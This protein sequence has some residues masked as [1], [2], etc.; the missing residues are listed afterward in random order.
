MPAPIDP[1]ELRTATDGQILKNCRWE[2][3]RASGPGGQK[4]N[5]T[6]SAIRLVHLPTQVAAIA[7]ESRSQA[8][9]RASALRRL[10][11][12]LTLELRSPID[13]D[14]FSLPPWFPE[15]C[16]GDRLHLS[17]RSNHYLPAMG[18]LL[19]V[20][21]AC[22]GSVSDTARILNLSTGNLARF[23]QHDEKMMAHINALRTARGLKP[24][25]F[26]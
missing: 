13:L 4:R 17:P 15:L 18:L 8:A 9:N 26:A 21:T 3:F 10:R 23:F 6:S 12:R 25:G 11:H 16:K 7:N 1:L 5:K 19:D 20:I 2:A 14:H 24:L 22:E